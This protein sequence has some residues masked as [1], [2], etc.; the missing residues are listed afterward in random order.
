MII[1]RKIDKTP[2]KLRAV[3]YEVIIREEYECT[4]NISA[5]SINDLRKKLKKRIDDLD[6]DEY[7]LTETEIE[8]INICRVASVPININKTNN[9]CQQKTQV[10]KEYVKRLT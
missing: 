5:T 9:V 2:N 1:K 3:G 4:Y 6:Y 10:N 8:E 7:V